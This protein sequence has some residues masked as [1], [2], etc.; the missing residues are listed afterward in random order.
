MTTLED[1]ILGE[2][3]HYYCSSDEEDD[4]YRGPQVVQPVDEPKGPQGSTIRSSEYT[5]PKG[6]INDWREFKKLQAEQNREK[7]EE[8][9]RLMKRLCLTG[10]TKAEEEQRRQEEEIDAE[11]L[12]LMSDEVMQVEWSQE[13]YFICDVYNKDLL[14]VFQEF[15]RKR[16]EEIT[17]KL[18]KRGHFGELV[19]L[20][21]GDDFLA[22]V[23]GEIN[24]LVLVHIYEQNVAACR[25]MNE[26]LERMAVEM[27]TIKFC[28]ILSTSAGT[29]VS[30]K[31]TALPA[32]LAY[33]NGQ[34]VGN[35]VRITDDLGDEFYD[36]DVENFL[37]EN[38]VIVER[39][40]QFA[41]AKVL[42]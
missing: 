42:H 2:K 39:G 24:S 5:G 27:P 15:Q 16:V 10:A 41:T 29:S 40:L 3:T 6:V 31:K 25:C 8:E 36:G 13:I 28:K 1:K 33:K 21:T 11:L 22:A 32:L 9:A 14:V 20:K 34:V 35:F 30:F 26:C 17:N 23:E 4:T 7:A 19:N 12:E 18:A 37:I 38:G